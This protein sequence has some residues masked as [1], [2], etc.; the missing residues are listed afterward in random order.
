MMGILGS[1]FRYLV[2]LNFLR[3]LGAFPSSVSVNEPP[4]FSG[5]VGSV[6]DLE[7]GGEAFDVVAAI[8]AT[9]DEW[10]LAKLEFA[11]GDGKE[12]AVYSHFGVGSGLVGV[13][14]VARRER[15]RPGKLW[16]R[17]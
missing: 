2:W 12:K 8:A 10:D 6:G 4:E 3:A 1:S 13:M 17:L 14:R 7:I 9:A 5:F 15:S 11:T 16:W